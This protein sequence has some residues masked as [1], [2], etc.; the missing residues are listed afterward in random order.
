MK[1]IKIK[2]RNHPMAWMEVNQM[3]LIIEWMDF[4]YIISSKK[5]FNKLIDSGEIEG[6]DFICSSSV[7]FPEESTD[8]KE[9]IEIC[10]FLRS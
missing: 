2:F 4:R 6:V 7:D 5:D 3:G 9:V 10:K 1:K 8:N